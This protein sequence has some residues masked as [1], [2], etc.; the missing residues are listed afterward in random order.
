MYHGGDNNRCGRSVGVYHGGD[1]NF[2][3]FSLSEENKPFVYS[4][5]I[6][7]MIKNYPDCVIFFVP[8]H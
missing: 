2:S 8:S 3:R 1:N 5:K 6:W 7:R 4:H